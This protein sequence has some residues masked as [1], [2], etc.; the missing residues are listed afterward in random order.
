[1]DVS[2]PCSRD[3]GVLHSC[4]RAKKGTKVPRK[5]SPRWK[6]RTKVE[7]EEEEEEGSHWGSLVQR[8]P[9]AENWTGEGGNSRLGSPGRR[10]MPQKLRAGVPAWAL[11]G[12]T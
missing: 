1:M 3:C 6:M 12:S 10:P 9:A 7:E 2:D 4:Y 8:D 5:R 11:P